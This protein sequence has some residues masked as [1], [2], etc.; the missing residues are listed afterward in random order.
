MVST[1]KKSSKRMRGVWLK[2]RGGFDQ[3]EFRHDIPIPQ[4]KPDD[5]LSR[6]STAAVNNT[7]INTRIAWYSKKERAAEDASW[8]GVPIQFPRIQGADLCGQIVLA[9][10]IAF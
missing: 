5:V 9:K 3:I 7:D 2:G 6:V 8:G 4:V 10:A 1:M